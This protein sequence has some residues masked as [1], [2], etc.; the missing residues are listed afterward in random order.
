MKYA[1]RVLAALLAS[2]LALAAL[3]GCSGLLQLA[4]VQADQSSAQALM[5]EIDTGLTYD[6]ALESDALALANWLAEEPSLLGTSDGWLMRKVAMDPNTGN[7]TPSSI[8]DFILTSSELA[9]NIP[10]TCTIGMRMYCDGNPYYDPGRLYAPAAE[11]A[12]Q[13]LRSYAS[14]SSRMGAVYLEYGG[15][16]YVVAVFE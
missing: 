13:T 9:V 16:V 1:K 5:K 11:G 10:E 4:T 8:N 12:A 14:G 2:V 7:M 3:T 6:P 15:T